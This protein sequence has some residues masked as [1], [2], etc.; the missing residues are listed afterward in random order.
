[1]QSLHLVCNAH[2]DPVWQWEWE[3]GA[4]AAIS[5]FRVAADLCDAYAHFIFNHNESL[6]YQWIEEYE[7]ALF[8]R[9]QDFV[10]R[11]KWHIMGGWY[12]QPDCNM[13][14]GE[15][16][17]R[18]ILVGKRYFREKFGVEPTT[19]INFDPFGH[20]RGLVQ[21][22]AKSGYDSYIFTRP[23]LNACPLPEEVF[24]WVG[25]DGSTVTGQHGGAYGS[26]LG[27]AREKIGDWMAK[28]TDQSLGM[29]LW[30]V[31][32]HGGGPSRYDLEQITALMTE[33]TGWN[34]LHS[35]PEAY[36]AALHDSGKE[37]HRVDYTLNSFSVGCYTSQIRIKQKHRQLEHMLLMTE[38]ILAHAALAGHFAYPREAVHEALKDLLFSEF[39][40]AL[41]GS[42]IQP[43]EEMVLRLLDHGM[44][45]LSRQ[46]G[47][48]FFSL[49]AGQPVAHE[50]EIPILIYN[51][52]PYPIRGTF[53]CEFMLADQNWTETF[54]D[55]AVYAG[56]TT[57]PS[58]VEKEQSN[59]NL[60]WR[61]RVAFTAELQPG[62]MNRFDCKLNRLPE[63]P[64]RPI[65]PTEGAFV[66]KTEELEV[67]INT[68]TGLLDRYCVHGVDHLQP[69]AFLPLAI[70]DNEDPWGMCV[71]RFDQVKGKFMLMSPDA[72]T[73]FSGVH[74][75]VLPSVRI[76]EDGPVRTVAETALAYYE[77]RVLLQYRLP[78]HGTEIEVVVRVHWNEKDTMLKLALPIALPEAD[79]LGQV[80]YGVEALRMDGR[81]VVSQ[82]WVAATSTKADAAFTCIN[83]GI[84]GSSWQDGVMRLSLLRSSAYT[85]HPI[86]ERPILPADRYTPRIDQGERLFHF[87][88]NGGAREESMAHIDR[89]ALTKNEP[90]VC[91]SYFPTGDG[92]APRPLA[93]LHDDTVQIT[94]LKQAE[95]DDGF[96]IRLFEP[97]GV[98]RETV[99]ELPIFDV[100]YPVALGAFEIKTLRFDPATQLFS[101]TDLLERPV[102]DRATTK[103]RY[104]CPPR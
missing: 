84:Y 38:R 59:L 104:N 18:Q 49:A 78:K 63:R 20:T 89:I 22:L 8:V 17:V 13:P 42:S 6:L 80:A 103:Y 65:I 37:L 81:E 97:T 3:E 58:Q 67:V 94:A 40:D 61:K 2:L 27:V 75:G 36:F 32:N 55:V 39:H 30:G 76:I 23:D 73:A 95:E 66:F 4:A 14:S 85:A 44:E 83:D 101:E 51:P 19:A 1:M 92:I 86:Y 48:A 56:E 93:I 91:L 45:I 77:S 31:G 88:I 102:D 28:H 16:L 98:A 82:Q 100:R 69:S 99:L 21:I 70:A 79:Y 72:G 52:H 34:I 24:T 50:G 26:G 74:T 9:I 71:D 87:W 54:T 53:E 62:T 5:T 60:D 46:R 12:V 90:P 25:Y 68:A 15:S 41:P 11:G 10:A 57:L 96:I 29:V 43:V 64:A 7:P 33:D 47:R 35:T